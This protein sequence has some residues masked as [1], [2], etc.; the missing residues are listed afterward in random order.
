MPR[1]ARASIQSSG[2]FNWTPAEGQGP[3]AYNLTVRVTDNGTPSLY[4][5]ETI[6]ITVLHTP[7]SPVY[8]FCLEADSSQHFYT[9][10]LAERDKLINNYSGV[11]TYEGVAFHAF[12]DSSQPGVAP[13]YRFWSGSTHF[14]T[15]KTTEKDK[16]LN[17][18]ANV[19]QYEGVAFHAYAEGFQPVGTHA[20]YRFWSGTRNTH[21]F[22]ISQTERDKLINNY[23]DVWTD[24]GTAWYAY[25][26]ETP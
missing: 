6:T 3:G 8:R 10:K 4:D 14:Y 15:M 22:T 9:I 19:W 7:G 5:E 20:V 24:E 16:L 1:R 23:S 21:F 12:T 13:V 2:V 26:P 25:D 11:W 18:Y 17:N